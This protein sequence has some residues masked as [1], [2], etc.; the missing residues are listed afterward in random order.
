VLA[1]EPWFEVVCL[2][3]LGSVSFLK[4]QYQ[5][6]MSGYSSRPH[7]RT[8]HPI[9]T[10]YERLQLEAASKNASQISSIL[11]RPVTGTS[12]LSKETLKKREM[13]AKRQKIPGEKIPGEKI[14]GAK[15][16]GAKM[17][18]AKTAATTIKD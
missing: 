2:F 4:R 13:A 5:Q 1:S 12:R 7:P 17:Q 14:P 3:S 8:H 16:L 6:N 10:E 9:S 15:M 18:G 11:Q